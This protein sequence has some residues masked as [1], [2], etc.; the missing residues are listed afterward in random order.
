MRLTF[1]SAWS[2]S[3]AQG[4]NYFPIWA[5]EAADL[6]SNSF[7]WAFGNGNN[8]PA[9]TGVVLPFDCELI[10]LGLTHEGNASTTVELW[11]NTRATGQRI[12]THHS[13][14]ALEHITPFAVSSGDVINF[15]TITGSSAS[16]GS[17]VVAWFRREAS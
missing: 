14:V 17:V 9:G 2:K 8:T 4:N 10:A 13:R 15:K 7:E 3:A 5:E 1:P 6:N 11:K 16:N 12:S